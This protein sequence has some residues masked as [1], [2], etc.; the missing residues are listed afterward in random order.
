M[1]LTIR[2]SAIRE[3]VTLLGAFSWTSITDPTVDKGRLIADP[4]V[5]PPPRIFVLPGIE[6]NEAGPYAKHDITMPVE[7]YVTEAIG[8][9]NPDELGQA[10]LGEL[11]KCVIGVET[12]GDGGAIEK[13][14]GM[15][16]TYADSVRYLD[17]GVTAYPASLG[18]HILVIAATFEFKYQTNYGD[19][20]TN[21]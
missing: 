13:S 3:L 7:V 20:Y 8:T 18:A 10:V 9:Q 14:G 12:T 16:T 4:D 21:D 5:A 15:S 11:I 19:P 17:G 2:D 6:Q 1:S